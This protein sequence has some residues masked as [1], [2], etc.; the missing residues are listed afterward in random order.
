MIVRSERGVVH[1][2]GLQIA[3]LNQ[4]G[5]LSKNLRAQDTTLLV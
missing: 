4:C 5:Q 1:Q 2:F 3:G